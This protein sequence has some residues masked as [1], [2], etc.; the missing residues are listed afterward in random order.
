MTDICHVKKLTW[1]SVQ[2][3]AVHPK[4]KIF[5]FIVLYK[6]VFP[7]MALLPNITQHEKVIFFHHPK[8]RP[9]RSLG[10]T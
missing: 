9:K 6:A 2:Y 4:K 8:D 5:S 7:N 3:A 10:R 1:H